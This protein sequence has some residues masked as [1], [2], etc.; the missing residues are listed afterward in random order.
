M[1]YTDVDQK[2]VNTIRLLA[3][4]SLLQLQVGLL[5]D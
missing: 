2:A 5:A 1:G 3:V 4:V